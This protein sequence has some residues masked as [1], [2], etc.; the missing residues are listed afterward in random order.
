MRIAVLYGGTSTEREVSLVSGRAVGLALC[1]RGHDVLLVDTATGD[2]LVGA[3]E[4]VAAASLAPGSPPLRPPERGAVEAVTGTAVSDADVVFVA[5]HGGYGENGTIQGLLEL[6]GKRYTGSGVLASALAMDKRMSK[7]AFRE[8]GVP[9][10]EWRVLNVGDSTPAMERAGSP[11]FP[12][13]ATPGDA[14][15]AARAVGGYPVIVKPNDQGSTVGLSLVRDESALAAAVALAGR[16]SSNVLVEEYIPG[17]ELTV[18]VFEGRALPAVEVAPRGGLYDY[19][20]KYTKGMTDYT[21]PA[22][23]PDEV[24]AALG[25]S[26]IDAFRATGCCGYARADYRLSPEG[27]FYCLEVNTVP[28]MTE[29]SLVPMAAREAGMDFGELCERIVGMALL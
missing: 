29:V 28:G 27:R 8:A 23:I 7:V 25:R 1:E 18:A 9:T 21:C 16:Y 11:L 22:D 14:P 20:S 19:E 2:E 3:R 24:A 13:D 15:E 5:L 6:A 17:R 4:A 26:G 10:P 12:E